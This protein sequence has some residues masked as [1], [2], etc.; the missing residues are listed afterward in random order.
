MFFKPC[1]QRN[2][3]AVKTS[4]FCSCYISNLTQLDDREKS[5]FIFEQWNSI[6]VYPVHVF[7]FISTYLTTI[8]ITYLT[9]PNF[10]YLKKKNNSY[11][12]LRTTR[13]R[14]HTTF[15]KHCMS[16]KFQSVNW[17]FHHHPVRQEAMWPLIVLFYSRGIVRL[18]TVEFRPLMAPLSIHRMTDERILGAGKMVNWHGKIMNSEKDQIQCNCVYHKSVRPDLR[19][20]LCINPQ[21]WVQ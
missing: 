14:P 1:N 17:I 5:V 7:L 9:F 16:S 10:S 15:K 12:S 19:L 6:L 13:R 11:V 18:Y 4:E 21:V 3:N 8:S 20:R 2:A